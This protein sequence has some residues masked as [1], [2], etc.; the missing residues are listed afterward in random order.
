MKIEDLIERAKLDVVKAVG[1]SKS[2]Q[3]KWLKRDIDSYKS[4]KF[5][6]RV[7]VLE[8]S[9]PRGVIIVN[10]YERMVQA[11]DAYGE[12]LSQYVLDVEQLKEHDRRQVAS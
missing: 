5:R 9:E 7:L 2:R 3:R 1:E 12:K 11:F 4:R 10:Y 8:G 6:I